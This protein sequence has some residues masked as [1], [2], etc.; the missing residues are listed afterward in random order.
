LSI[1][2]QTKSFLKSTFPGGA[3]AYGRVKDYS[4]DI[5]L[6]DRDAEAIFSEIYERNLWNDPESAS[7]RG[8]TL[9][10]TTV[11]R[12]ELPSLLKDVG[13]ESLLDA[14][15]G[16]FN[17]MK[18]TKLSL[19]RYIGAD[20]VPEIVEANQRRYASST[21]TF[22]ELDIAAEE[23]PAV[24]VILCRDCLVHF[25]FEDAMNTIRNFKR[26]KSEYLL[27]TTFTATETNEDILTGEWRP[28]NLQLP[29]FNFPE[30]LRLINEH[31]TEDGG[32]HSDKSLGLWRLKDLLAL[33]PW[34]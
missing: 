31:C 13:A 10:R 9:Q 17:W 32:R 34:Y 1:L 20:I 21:L 23:L 18:E 15:C 33:S 7:G 22:V 3:L 24:D 29:P 26:S 19:D 8:S 30:P 12:R 16:D 4:R 27:T 25:S 5:F 2:R 28:L 6:G 14:P 11:I